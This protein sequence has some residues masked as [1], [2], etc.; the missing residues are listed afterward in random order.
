MKFNIIKLNSDKSNEEPVWIEKI[1]SAITVVSA[2]VASMVSA[3]T[4]N[5]LTLQELK[6]EKGSFQFVEVG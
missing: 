3:V 2:S 4:A 6:A 1:T 5:S